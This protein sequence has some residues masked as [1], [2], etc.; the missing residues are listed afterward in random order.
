MIDDDSPEWDEQTTA[1]L[2]LADKLKVTRAQL[3][4]TQSDYAILLRVSLATLRNWEQR[5]TTPDGL[6]RTLIDL[7]Y[8]Y[9]KDMRKK[10][11]SEAA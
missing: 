5:R 7:V 11:A 6:A 1:P 10:L 9:P 3:G 4:L 2:D 8:R